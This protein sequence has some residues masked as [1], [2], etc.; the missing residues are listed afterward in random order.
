MSE[1]EFNRRYGYLVKEYQGVFTV[2]ESRGYTV[3]INKENRLYHF[4]KDFQKYTGDK[5]QT[6][7]KQLRESEPEVISLLNRF[8]SR[9]LYEVPI[10]QGFCMPYGFIAGDSGYEKRNMGVT[11]R[12]KAHPD[13]TIFFQDY[14]INGEILTDKKSMKDAMT[15]MWNTQYLMGASKKELLSPKWQRI[16][17]A[18]REGMGTFV[19][20]TYSNV[21]VY[22]YE[23]HVN[24]RLNY[25]NYGYLAYVRGNKVNRNKEPDLLL[26][27]SQD[28]RQ[29]KN[30]PPMDKN[31]LEKL[32][33][34]IVSSVK[35][36]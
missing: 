17:M 3:Y 16:S 11:Y 13:V 33:E 8:K 15:R 9:K 29:V 5:S 25:I 28:S 10:E 19:K 7:E 1:L 14:A 34:H 2:Y 6:A 26:Y 4:W 32:A 23:G 27:V 20:A 12:L 30:Q 22:D 21:P 35:R 31:E 36:R 24:E 18:G